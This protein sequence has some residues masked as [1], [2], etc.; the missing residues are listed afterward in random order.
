ML[1]RNNKYKIIIFFRQS[2]P[3]AVHVSMT[4]RRFSCLQD[5]GV[6]MVPTASA[7]LLAKSATRVLAVCA[8]AAGITGWAGAANAQIVPNGNFG[9]TGTTSNLTNGGTFDTTWTYVSTSTYYQCLIVGDTKG[10]CGINDWVDPGYS[11]NGAN[12]LAIETETPGPGTVQETIG[13]LTVGSRYTLTFYVGQEATGP[14]VWTVSLGGTTLNTTTV[15]TAGWTLAPVSVTFTATAPESGGLLAFAATTTSGG[16]P[17]ALLDGVSI[18]AAP[19][20]A[21]L[22]LL[23]LGGIAMV[24]LRRRRASLAA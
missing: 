24:G 19:E 10:A 8:L 23:G 22:A 18:V 1:I 11:P 6:T 5:K 14:I 2:Q 7:S 21:S 16:P 15:S 13:A 4:H 20:P 3:E 12:Y 9:T 17:I